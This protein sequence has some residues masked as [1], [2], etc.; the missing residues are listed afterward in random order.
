MAT[1]PAH[2]GQLPRW[3]LSTVYPSLE[4]K[5]FVS[6]VSDVKSKIDGLDGFLDEHQISRSPST[7]AHKLYSPHVKAAITGF[8]D[9]INAEL[10]L[11]ATLNAY[12]A[13]FVTTD[14]Y[15]TTAKRLESELELLAV[16]IQ[17]QGIRFEGWLGQMSDRLPE[18]LKDESTAKIHEFYLNETVEQ[19]R[20]MMGETEETLAAEL[21]LSGGNAWSKLQGTVCS[22]LSV[23]FELDGEERKM[24]ITELQNLK[25]HREKSVRRRSYEAEL[26]AWESVREPLAAALNGVKGSRSTLNKRRRRVDA[27]HSALDQARIDRETLQTLL[28]AMRES[29]PMFRRY[30][31]AKA[32]RFGEDALPWWDIFAPTGRTQTQY[33][34]IEAERFILTQFRSFSDRL[35]NLAQRA[36]DHY[37]IDAE[38]RDGKRGGAFCME[39]PAVDE[40]RILCNFDGSLDQVSTVAHELGHAFHNECQIGK[41]ILQTQTPMTLAETA[42]TFCETIVS[43][44]ALSRASDRQEELAI[45]ETSLINSS[46]VIVDIT[47]RY[48]FEKEV[49]E[50]RENSELSADDFC[51]IMLRSQ[52]ETYGEGLDE[53]FLNKY[54][55]A[56]KSHYY[57]ADISFYNFPYAFGLLFGTGLYAIYKERGRSFTADYEALLAGTG[58]AIPA[59]LAQRFGIDI[60]RSDFWRN[61]LKI[62]QQN[63]DRYVRL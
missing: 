54:M 2:Q 22:Q 63:V 41:T 62:I 47:S 53:R 1:K 3:D 61:S 33:T 5:Q 44:A 35:A 27:V 60:H 50:R 52:Q 16:R 59:A 38:P 56:W 24:P 23:N 30:F 43:E 11:F 55:W 45:L 12:V 32:K 9:R 18:V 31:K 48:L 13:S 40:S 46:Q 15:N 36:F 29:F 28:D 19:S 39:V 8:L 10:R 4:S 37:W 34:W 21:E 51:E 42:S 7:T 49:F 20:Y 6:A 25:Y 57:M 58:E 26:A 17:K 14:S